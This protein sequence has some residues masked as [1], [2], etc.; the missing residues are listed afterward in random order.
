MDVCGEALYGASLVQNLFCVN[1]NPPINETYVPSQLRSISH[2]F[3]GVKMHNLGNYLNNWF[4]SWVISIL[5]LS[6]LVDNIN[7]L[8]WGQK[9]QPISGVFN[10]LHM[11]PT[12]TVH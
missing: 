12:Q 1:S 10:G 3:S 6:K 5:N 8:L 4:L 11:T 2:I 9:T 7:L